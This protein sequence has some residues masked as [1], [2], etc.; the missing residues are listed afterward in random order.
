[1]YKTAAYLYFGY[2]PLRCQLNLF[3]LVNRGDFL[4]AN[5]VIPT[6]TAHIHVLTTVLGMSLNLLKYIII[7]LHDISS[8][9]LF[10]LLASFARL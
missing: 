5:V 4:V 6:L 3:C 9:G 8:L 1:M 2:K 7:R 10:L